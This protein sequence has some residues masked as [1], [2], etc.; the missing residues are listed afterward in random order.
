MT[1]Q[2]QPLKNSTKS[3]RKRRRDIRDCRKKSEK[4]SKPVMFTR[5]KRSLLRRIPAAKLCDQISFKIFIV[6]KVDTLNLQR[7]KREQPLT[8]TF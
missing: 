5:D 8:N 1:K 3:L 2:K 6:A 7:G 4:P